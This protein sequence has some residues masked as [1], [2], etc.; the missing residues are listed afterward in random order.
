MRFPSTLLISAVLLVSAGVLQAQTELVRNAR[1]LER[2]GR[3]EDALRV[4]RQLLEGDPASFQALVGLERIYTRLG[5]LDSIVPYLAAAEQVAPGSELVRELQIRVWGSKERE[6]SVEAVVTRWMRAAPDSAAPYRQWAFWL[7]QRGEITRALR[8]LRDGQSRLGDVAL[9]REVAEVLGYA[10]DWAGS[11]MAWRR[12]VQLDESV[13]PAAVASLREAPEYARAGML[14]LLDA[15]DAQAADRRLAADLLLTWGRAEEAWTRLDSALPA[16]RAAAIVLLAQFAERARQ[17]RTLGGA[18]ARGYAL[19]RLAGLASGAEAEKARLEA[20]QAF[21]DA[22]DLRAA[23]RMLGGVTLDPRARRPDAAAT[24]GA[25]IRVLADAG[26]A[27]EAEELFR[28]WS[29][30]LRGEDEAL[31]REKLAWARVVQGQLDRAERLV[32]SDSSI[33]ARAVK[34]WIALYRGDLAN[35]TVHFRAAGPYAQSREEATQRTQV[36]ALIQRIVPDTVP[37]LGS[38]LQ[39]LVR[40]DT[41][42]AL[43]EL[44]AAA[45]RLPAQGGRPAVLAFAGEVAVAAA[46]YGRAEELLLDAIGLDERGPSAPA[47]E[48][49][50]AVSYARV[51]RNADAIRLLENL[52]LTHAES[53]IV[54]QARRLLDQMKGMVP[55]S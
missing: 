9:A 19:E 1:E 33:G 6:D 47:A 22:G 35:A 5:R 55:S 37:K 44:A 15:R 20:A 39:R 41:V 23:Q 46:E 51:G 16:D 14:G 8:V 36:L 38:A 13:L 21:A 54:P 25:L 42:Q 7:A 4:Y 50:L 49:A 17:V 10:E 3:Y 26:R 34:G 31:L 40:G 30:S 52:I 12:A 27:D 32:A 43:D 45:R 18:R 53:A 2:R 24:M 28:Q 29:K 11:T 48:Y